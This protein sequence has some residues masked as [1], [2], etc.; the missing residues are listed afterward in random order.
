MVQCASLTC[1]LTKYSAPTGLLV[2]RLPDAMLEVG[3]FKIGRG[4]VVNLR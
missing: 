4:V 1:C 3:D 2:R